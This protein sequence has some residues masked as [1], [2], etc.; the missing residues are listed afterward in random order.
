MQPH[1]K[2]LW[3]NITYFIHCKG[4][5]V[6]VHVRNTVVVANDI[7]VLQFCLVIIIVSFHIIHYY[8]I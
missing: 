3:P 6:N 2:F 4:I 8:I 5:F 1:M 7:L